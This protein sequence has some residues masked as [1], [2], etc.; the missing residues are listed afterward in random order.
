MLAIEILN[1]NKTYSPNIIAVNN[2]SLSIEQ[3]DFFAILGPNGSGK[4]TTLGIIS[5]LVT[6]DSG[7]VKIFG[8]SLDTELSKAKSFIGIVPQEFNFSIFE[9]LIEILVNQAG[10]FGIKKNIAL[11]RAE[12]FLKQLGLWHK[13]DTKSG[14]LSGGMKRRLMIARAMMHSPKILILDEPSAGLDIEARHQIWEFLELINKNQGITIILTTHYLEEAERLCKKLAI[15]EAG[16]IID[17]DS[18]ENILS[19]FSAQRYIAELVAPIANIPNIDGVLFKLHDSSKL[20]INFDYP[21]T[22]SSVIHQLSNK[23][24]EVRTLSLKGNRLE[25]LFFNLRMDQKNEY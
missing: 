1:L 9:T 20:E 16:K 25:E 12:E 7:I 19:R 6:K 15:I 14:Q 8:N 3:G 18:M 2:V 10:Y 22:I 24:I 21:I 4:T 17:C 23:N 11:K 13:K 5:S